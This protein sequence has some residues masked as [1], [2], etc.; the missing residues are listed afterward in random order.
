[1]KTELHVVIAGGGVAGLTVAALLAKEA[2]ADALRVTLLESGERPAY[3]ADDDIAL[4]VSAVSMGSAEILGRAG[5]W[6]AVQG[7][8]LC[9]YDR[10]RVWD[11]A[12][13]PDAASALKFD[14]DEFA[15]AH[16]GYIV[17]NHL[18]QHALLESLATSTVD[19]QF[20]MPI[21]AIREAGNGYELEFE[22]GPNANADLVIAADGGRSF[23][24][25]CAGIETDRLDYDQTAFVTHVRP[26]RPH[27][28]TAS[29]RFLADGPL[30]MLPLAD[31]RLSIVWSTHPA[32][33]ERA[34]AASDDELQNMLGEASD[35]VLGTLTPEGPRGKFPLSAQHARNY[36]SHALALV[37][38][39]AHTI[40]PLAGQGANLGIADAEALASVIAA[41][42][43]AGEYPAD[44][45]VLRRYERARRGPNS[46]MMH[47]MTGLNRLF[48]S[49][50][51]YLGE[52]RRLGM[53]L[54]NRSGPLRQQIV[55]VALGTGR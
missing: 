40:H 55:E 38:D 34:L 33:V 25:E 45:P 15:V 17:E 4:R 47:F 35:H 10:M 24:R 5:A 27:A 29:Q 49:D 11:A 41:A 53:Q 46:A 6:P 44:R 2:R 31:G 7:A 30:G 28:S 12:A 52:M 54:F 1:M 37:G 50:S 19:L 32:N 13:E 21:R 43:E 16:L 3:D 51:R 42:L 26:E 18:L 14:A 9:P 48:A 36:V 22:N 39:A 8:R 23:I 20:G